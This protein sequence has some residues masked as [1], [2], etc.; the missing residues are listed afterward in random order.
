M[1]PSDV[2][3]LVAIFLSTVFSVITIVVG[4]YM[5]RDRTRLDQLEL[6]VN[7]RADVLIFFRADNMLFYDNNMISAKA[8]L[9]IPQ[10]KLFRRLIV[11]NV[12]QREATNIEISLR[13]SDDKELNEETGFQ[14]WKKIAPI[15]IL[16]P[17]LEISFPYDVSSDFPV[18]DIVDEGLIG[19]WRWKNPDGSIDSRTSNLDFFSNGSNF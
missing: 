13:G 1:E 4:V 16:A 11:K 18:K 19:N 5:Q 3:S 8:G 2:L 10:T 15:K 12:G 9:P 6:V 14:F 17:G 7:Q